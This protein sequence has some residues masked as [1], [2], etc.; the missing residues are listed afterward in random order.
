M[1]TN[2]QSENRQ[3]I[4][5]AARG[6][7][8]VFLAL[9]LFSATG[10]TIAGAAS[11]VPELN[12]TGPLVPGE[13]VPTDGAE[14]L[15]LAAGSNITYTTDG[16]MHVFGSDGTE[17]F[18]AREMNATSIHFVNSETSET[19]NVSATRVIKCH[20]STIFFQGEEH[21][22]EILNGNDYSRILFI[23]DDQ[24]VATTITYMFG[25]DDDEYTHLT[26]T[27]D[28]MTVGETY[29]IAAT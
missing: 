3:G 16:I 14:N 28:V 26:E 10:C 17:Q 22:M 4:R 7:F 29:T 19:L 18:T 8:C 2:K 9:V 23:H 15:V 25:T 1:K 12:I 13:T 20:G 24:P 27:N 5:K 11:T 21:S 6:V